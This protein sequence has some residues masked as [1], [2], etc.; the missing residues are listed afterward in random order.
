MKKFLVII[1]S[2]FY[3]VLPAFAVEELPSM[4]VFV[5][6]N[7]YGLKDCDGNVVVDPIYRKLIRVGD[8]TWIARKNGRYGLID[9]YGQVLVPIRY[10]HADRIVGKFSKF[11]NFNNFGLYDEYGNRILEHEYSS[12]DLL[13]GKMF[14][15]CYRH[16]YGVTDFDG[17]LLIENDYDDIYMPDKNSIRVLYEGNWF[18]LKKYSDADLKNENTKRVSYQD[19]D[20]TITRLVTQTGKRSSYYAVSA[21][22]YTIKLLSSISPA[23][24]ETIDDLMLSHGADTVSII[25]KPFWI[26][27]FPYVYMKKYIKNV[28]A[29]NNG[30]LSDF[31]QKLKREI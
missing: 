7:E 12:I 16:K 9:S 19:R 14:L 11:G 3:F 30:P 2:I 29:P 13:Y 1:C 25:T 26:V 21:T 22:D 10:R 6:D 15:T 8:S 4:T 23:Y 28:L 20:F 5:E 17:N 24:E 27:Q 18:E 31:K